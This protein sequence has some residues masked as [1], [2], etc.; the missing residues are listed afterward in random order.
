MWEI[1]SSVLR[2]MTFSAPIGRRAVL[3]RLSSLIIHGQ[4]RKIFNNIPV[5]NF[6]PQWGNIHMNLGQDASL[7]CK[8]P[9]SMGPRT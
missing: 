4:W 1:E 2:E 8:G 5:I 6:V 7:K 3:P 9:K